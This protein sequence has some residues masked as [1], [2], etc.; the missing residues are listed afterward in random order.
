MKS[1]KIFFISNPVFKFLQK[2]VKKVIKIIINKFLRYSS[3]SSFILLV[4][5]FCEVKFFSSDRASLAILN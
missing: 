5:I 1:F 2:M 3:L 4:T